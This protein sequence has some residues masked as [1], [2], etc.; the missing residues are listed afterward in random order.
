MTRTSLTERLTR[1]EQQRNRLQQAE[2]R[3]KTDERKARTRRLIEAGGLVDKAGLVELEPDTLHSAFLAL[4]ANAGDAATLERWRKAGG[5]AFD[6][7]AKARDAGKEPLVLTLHGPQP[8]TVTTHL[9]SQ[10]F[11]WSK[12]M[13]HWE[14]ITHHDQALALATE[15]GGSLR[16][17]APPGSEE[18]DATAAA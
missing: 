11:R 1:L 14:G 3:I 8:A 10:G 15:L 7:E 6:R 5:Q 12:V 16:R 13:Q 9:R 4:N 17:L 2:T 18:I